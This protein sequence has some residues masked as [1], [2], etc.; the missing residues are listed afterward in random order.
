MNNNCLLTR[1]KAVVNDDSLPIVETMQ[2][3]TLDAIS[4][5]GNNNMTD[6]QKWAL[7]HFFYSI[8]AITN[9]G[10]YSKLQVLGLPFIG[11]S[12]ATALHNYIVGGDSPKSIDRSVSFS[13]GSIGSTLSSGTLSV[14]E[15]SISGKDNNVFQLVFGTEV[16]S[17][18]VRGANRAYRT[19]YTNS[20]KRAQI[21]C[22]P[23][24]QFASAAINIFT[25]TQNIIAFNVS[26]SNNIKLCYAV[27]DN[28]DIIVPGILHTEE[29]L[30]EDISTYIPE[31]D[32]TTQLKG[33]AYG[34]E[35]TDDEAL[36][37][38]QAYNTLIQAFNS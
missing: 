13:D 3:F 21:A 11:T 27:G 12:I 4:A 29:I 28:T 35:L 38:T 22:S 23:Y 6:A 19:T 37:F 36:A 10:I 1:L 20:A 17:T 9:S 5:S 14:C 16:F 15:Y 34:S 26:D 24:T 30:G 2:Q 31:A 32:P 18:R 25:E 7:N 8:G 33:F